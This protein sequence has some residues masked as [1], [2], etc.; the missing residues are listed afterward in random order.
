MR[1]NIGR[2]NG[3]KGFL[4]K[5]IN[6]ISGFNVNFVLINIQLIKFGYSL[7]NIRKESHKFQFFYRV[8]FKFGVFTLLWELMLNS[9]CSKG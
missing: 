8:F 3:F 5:K 4:V 2:V 1:F 7:I 9:L 6:K